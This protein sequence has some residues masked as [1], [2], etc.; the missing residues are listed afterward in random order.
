MDESGGKDKPLMEDS[1]ARSRDT[2]WGWRCRSCDLFP[3]A[4][5]LPVVVRVLIKLVKESRLPLVSLVSLVVQ[6]DLSPAGSSTPV[7]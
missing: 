3:S 1:D 6:V 2:A 7:N 5:V 4:S